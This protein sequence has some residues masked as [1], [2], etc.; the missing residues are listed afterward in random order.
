MVTTL[1]LIEYLNGLLEP[2]LF[3]DYC[4]NGLQVAGK[5]SIRTLV[6]GVSACQ[7]LLDQAAVRSA[8]AV[9]VHHGFFW[10]G[11]DRCLVGHMRKRIGCL[12]EHDINLIAYHLPLDAHDALGNNT[13]LAQLL[14]IHATGLFGFD[15]GPA[16]G[17][18]GE[19]ERSFSASEFAARLTSKLQRAPLHIAAS[20]HPIKRVAWCTGAAQS[21]LHEAIK[22]DVDAFITGEVSEQSVHV[23]RENNI[24]YFAAGH[25]ATERYGVQA[26]GE[27]LAERFSL[28]HQFIDIDNPV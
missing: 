19:M 10:K 20:D 15:N 21:Y 3:K 6:T 9:L 24:H 28:D 23:A 17:R 5:K 12:I 8:D 27:H 25:H 14:G 2:H 4:P 26:L 13:Q 11:E 18:I 16:L 1:D 22:H 7:L